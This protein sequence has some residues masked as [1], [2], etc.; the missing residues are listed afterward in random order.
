[1]MKLG[2]R[3]ACASIVVAV[4]GLTACGS[5]E[6]KGNPYQATPAPTASAA[7]DGAIGSKVK[8][9]CEDQL[10]A[11]AV[12]SG[13][14]IAGVPAKPYTVASVTFTGEVKEVMLPYDRKAWEVPLTATNKFPDGST[15]TQ[16]ETC[17]FRELQQDAQML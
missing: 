1:M 2:A 17:R 15:K 3:L 14:E 5:L 16:V 13:K 12:S 8:K 10:K 7:V 11:V 6:P 9:A 4:V